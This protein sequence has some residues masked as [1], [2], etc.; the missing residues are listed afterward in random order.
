MCSMQI[1]EIENALA[2]LGAQVAAREQAAEPAPGGAV[3]RIGED[4][5]RAV[6]EHQ[7]R[8]GMIGEA[9]ASARA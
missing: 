5:G 3:A 8:A 1:V 9:S 6:G 7:P 2:L 4:V